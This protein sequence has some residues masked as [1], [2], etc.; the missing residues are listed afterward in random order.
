MALLLFP[1]LNHQKHGLNFIFF[2]IIFL[3]TAAKFGDGL[4]PTVSQLGQNPNNPQRAP[5]DDTIDTDNGPK[6]EE[7][8]EGG[9]KTEQLGDREENT[10]SR[11]E[12]E[13]R[14]PGKKGSEDSSDIH[15]RG[16]L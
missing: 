16:K 10:E 3:N 12:R 9:T 7:N 11:E 8:G 13:G 14:G 1:S 6:F 5:P 15:R 4:L 2:A